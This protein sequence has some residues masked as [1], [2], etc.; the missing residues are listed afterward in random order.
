MANIELSITAA[1]AGEIVHDEQGSELRRT[2]RFALITRRFARRRSALAGLVLLVLLILF[3]LLGPLVG[4]WAYDEP[5]F[6]A[7]AQ[8]PGADHWFGT[9]TGG[10]D[11]FALVARGLGRSLM[12]GILSSIA[13][14]V[15]AAVIGTTVAFFEGW[16]ERVGMW[17]LDTLLVVP[18]FLLIAMITR[19]ASGT[20]GWL[21][22][23]LALTAF[24][25]VGY[26]RIL[27]TLTLS[28]RELDYVH[29][30]RY[31]GV[32]SSTIIRRHLIPNL[33]SVLIIQ[34]VLGVVGAVNSET[35]LSFLGLGVQAPDTSL[36]T[37]L[38]A[39][40]SVVLTSPWVLLAPSIFLV[41]LTFSM[42][43]IGDGLRDAID[44]YS[45]SGGK[46]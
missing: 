40:Q 28:L 30:A 3:A 46:A 22:L 37:I 17:I 11:V 16:V 36:G 21:V 19:S 42:Q 1:T 44:P 26:A 5:D 27:R 43:L 14:T 31:M 23:A 39:G 7:L 2:G 13:T 45:R 34:T 9:T 29:A 41:C 38:Q 12:I 18:S 15:V 33:G 32:R 25:W 8:P 10:S 4:Q 20:G 6:L 35:A 24:G